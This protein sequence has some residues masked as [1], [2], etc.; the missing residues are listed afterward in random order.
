MTEATITRKIERT[1]KKTSKIVA[2]IIKYTL[3]IIVSFKFLRVEVV[4]IKIIFRQIFIPQY[5][6]SH[7]KKME[8]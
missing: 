8:T 3:T 2:S 6:Q 1:G 5:I 7:W 4:R